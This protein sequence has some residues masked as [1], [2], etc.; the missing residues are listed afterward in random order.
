MAMAIYHRDGSGGADRR[1]KRVEERRGV[2]TGTFQ[3]P[4]FIRITLDDT[5]IQGGKLRKKQK[6]VE[7][8]AQTFE[9]AKEERNRRERGEK[10]AAETPANRTSLGTAIHGFIES[11]KR[12]SKA[13]VNN[14]TYILNEF[15]D[16]SSAKFVDEVTRKVLDSYISWL[17]KEQEAAPKTIQNKTQV[18]VFMLKH[19]G[20][21]KPSALVKDLVPTVEEE[22]AEPYDEKDLEKLFD[23]MENK[24]DQEG[25]E[26]LE[27]FEAF[28][29]FLVTACREKEVAHAKWEDIVMKGKVPHYWV[30]AK[31]Y[32]KSNGAAGAFSPKNHECRYIPLT[33]DLVNLLQNRKKTSKS[34]WIFPNE[35]GDPQGHLLRKFKKAAFEAGLNCGKCETTRSEGRYEKVVVKKNCK[36]YSQGCE[37]HYLHR[38]RK[39]RATFWHKHG[40][41]LRTIQY[42]LA[43]KDLTT[44]LRNI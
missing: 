1:Y 7:L 31:K 30:H 13:T 39:T 32:T 3:P 18:I 15:L 29:F 26:D 9:S 12:K 23:W 34:D 16:Q 17:E 42:W 6:W 25:K 10:L 5:S 11:K 33:E 36:T 28:T 40:I 27:D 21:Q 37:K 8:D 14:Y 24:K 2:N 4:F 43:H 22:P 41:P 38:L 19:A 44:T 35:N 20:V